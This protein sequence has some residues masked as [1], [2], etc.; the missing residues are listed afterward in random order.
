MKS[1]HG[2][3][4]P[5]ILAQIF[6]MPKS[7]AALKTGMALSLVEAESGAEAAFSDCFQLTVTAIIF[8]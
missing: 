3:A 4:E 2:A 6:A 1:R 7:C 8:I 5:E